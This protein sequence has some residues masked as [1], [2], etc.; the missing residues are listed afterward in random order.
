MPSTSR[1]P[2]YLYR[3]TT[4][5]RA[6][7]ILTQASIFFPS[8]ADFND[9]FDCKFRPVSSASFLKR[10]RF[11][12]ELIRERNPNL[13]K[14]QVK[15]WARRASSK[16][17]FEEG[18]RRLM[19]R[20]AASVGMLCLT[21]R[22]DSILMWSHYANRHQGVCVQFRGLEELPCPPLPIVYSDKYPELDLL[23]YE[24]FLARQD[25][26][27]RAKQ[28]ELVERMY[29]TKAKDWSY[30]H[31]WRIIDWAAARAGSRGF[32]SINPNHLTGIIFG[33]RITK[34]DGEK[35]RACVVQ[36]KTPIRLY[37]AAQSST[38]FRLDLAEVD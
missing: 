32:H 8:P 4:V 2:E 23:A 13:P 14:R 36:M 24:P 16:A 37:Q 20:I 17:S 26:L 5:D 19:A 27:A 34:E 3:F 10:Q 28:R 33:C 29:L 18:T 21:S 30:E 1:L 7:E 25:E 6:E 38:A 11:S 15:Q 22:N 35:I 12:R 9:P 31:E